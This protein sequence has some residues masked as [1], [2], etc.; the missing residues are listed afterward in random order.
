MAHVM[1]DC[2]AS[3]ATNGAAN[4]GVSGAV[5]GV[6]SDGVHARTTREDL[7]SLLSGLRSA[8]QA[9]AADRMGAVGRRRGLL[10]RRFLLGLE[11]LFKLEEQLLLPALT[12]AQDHVN[13]DTAQ[14]LRNAR[15]EI[16][17]LRDLGMLV[18]H[19]A[20]GNRDAV[21]GVLQGLAEL[22]EQRVD[23]LIASVPATSVPW[24]SLEREM[25]GQLGRWRA[26]VISDG[27]IDDEDRDPVGLR[28]R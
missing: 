3:V 13:A 27:D 19:T 26:E 14:S 1:T 15:L 10:Q 23:A 8:L 22:H 17:L 12:D 5:P 24:Q 6:A 20:S 18:A 21:V 28:P 16:E 11:L 4:R 2:L 9:V 25:R 7:S